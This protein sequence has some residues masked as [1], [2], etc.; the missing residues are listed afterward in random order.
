MGSLGPVDVEE[1][2]D[3]LHDV[4]ERPGL[5]AGAHLDRVAVHRIAR[6]DHLAPF[7]LHGPDQPRQ[8]G[9]DLVMAHAGDDRH[10]SRLVGRV[11]DVDQPQQVVRVHGGAGLQ[12]QGIGEAAGILDVGA[13][14]VARAVAQPDQVRRGVV[15]VTRQGVGTGHGLLEAE[16]E[17]LM[18]GVQGRGRH[19]RRVGFRQAAGGHEAQR[20]GDPVGDLAVAL[21]LRGA[22][23]EV[24]VPVVDLVQPGVAAARER[25]Q[26]VERGCRLRV[27]A[28]LALGIGTTG[29]LV[30]VEA[31]D[32]VAAV[33]RQVHAVLA[34][35]GR[36]PGLGELAGQPADLDD[37]EAGAEGQDDRHLQQHAQRVADVVGPELGEAFGA[38][39]ALQQERPALRDLGQLRLQRSRLAGEHQRR[40]RRQPGLDLGELPGIGIVRDLLRRPVPPGARRPGAG[41]IPTKRHRRGLRLAIRDVV[42]QVVHV[43]QPSIS[44]RFVHEDHQEVPTPAVSGTARL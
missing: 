41:M 27:G 29:C 36:G 26:Q 37:A 13:I 40:E 12:P 25:P 38:V 33:A 4:L 21:A 2:L 10:P 28:H 19:T 7:P 9:L 31:V 42:K 16:Q 11:E 15:P 20:L 44:G 39:A 5:E 34:L 24:Q 32:D 18:R 3:L 43:H 8:V 6:P 1:P 35:E 22:G 14:E 30:E 17:R 23:H